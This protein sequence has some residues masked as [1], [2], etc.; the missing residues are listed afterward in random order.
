MVYKNEVDFEGSYWNIPTKLEVVFENCNWTRLMF[1]K[2]NHKR[3]GAISDWN[4]N[5]KVGVLPGSFFIIKADVLKEIGLFD[6][7]TFLYNEENILAIRL[8]EKGYGEMLSTTDFYIHNH[9]PSIITKKTLKKYYNLVKVNYQSR[10]Y[11][12]DTYYRN[13]LVSFTLTCVQVINY[14]DMTVRFFGGF[15]KRKLK[16]R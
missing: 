7:G 10:K 11:L 5:A 16:S 4:G 13:K 2:R 8:R 15:I 14:F 12:C 1:N 9:N 6:E 3:I